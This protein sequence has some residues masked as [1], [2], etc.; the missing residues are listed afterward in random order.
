MLVLF[1]YNTAEEMRL[2]RMHPEMMQAD[3]THGTN[4][5]KK[6]LFTLASLDGNNKA[7]DA[8]RGFIPN[9]QKWV[10]TTLFA[11]CL[12]KLFGKLITERNKLMLTD[13]CSAEYLSF[14]MNSGSG[15]VY[16]NSCLGLCYFHLV[17]QGWNK[18]VRPSIEISGVNS[19]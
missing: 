6:E 19:I 17:I 8:L 1:I 16:K 2:T 14:I 7:F 5:E 11:E 9:A 12:P 13:G 15:H 4:K 3:T 18:H 10:F